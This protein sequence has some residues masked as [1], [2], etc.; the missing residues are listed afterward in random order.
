QVP[1]PI[2]SKI[3]IDASGHRCCIRKFNPNL[4]GYL[5]DKLLAFA[6]LFESTPKTCK[7]IP[8]KDTD[9]H[10]LVESCRFGWWQTS[11]LPNS[12]CIVV[13]FTDDDLIKQYYEYHPIGNR[14]WCLAANSEALSSF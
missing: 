14:I 1:N 7:D 10:T 13:F 3:L 8:T 9:N 6:C 2:Y 11:L 5:F 12:R 4:K